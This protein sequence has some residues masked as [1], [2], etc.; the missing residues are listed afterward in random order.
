MWRL[1]LSALL[2]LSVPAPGGPGRPATEPRA[3]ARA[4]G[5]RSLEDFLR[6]VA[7][8]AAE[9]ERELRP[10]IERVVRGLEELA[11]PPDEALLSALRA[12]LEHLGDPA[13]PLLVPWLDPGGAPSPGARLRA[14]EI[15]RALERLDTAALTAD[16]IALSR[17]GSA[18]GRV[19][20]T[21]LLGRAPVHDRQARA[22]LQEL[23]EGSN[24]LLRRAAA[25]GLAGQDSPERGAFLA[26]ALDDPDP[27]L[28]GGVLAALAARPG[29]EGLDPLF[30][31]LRRPAAAAPWIPS[32][33]AYLRAMHPLPE[34]RLAPLVALVLDARLGRDDRIL[35][36]RALPDLSDD[37]SSEEQRRL[38]T[39]SQNPDPTLREAAL[40]CLAN[41]GDRG[42]RRDLLRTY[43]QLV[44]ANPRWP[45]AFRSR[46]EVLLAVGEPRDAARD[47]RRAIELAQAQGQR[48]AAE[49][50]ILLAR[51][52]LRDDKLRQAFETLEEARLGLEERATLAADEEFRR[53][54]EHARYGRVL[55]G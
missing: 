38:G 41:L 17:T 55:G 36:L 6:R 22:R 23:F 28:V 18:L 52:Y 35:L 9:L 20:A 46:G 32:V 50:W 30:A 53:L 1:L 33:V 24:P 47:F 25:R 48:P 45:N 31:L 2:G 40:V 12:E 27:E 5:D 42:A 39:L 34:E 11:Q 3:A 44:D 43:D 7:G 14:A 49:V 37:W 8:R 51:A 10:R 19:S 26:R 13:A 54:R 15:R 16:L 21:E 4:D 29:E